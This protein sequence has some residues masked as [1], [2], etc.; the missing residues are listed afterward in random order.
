MKL[1][2]P[3][4]FPLVLILT[5]PV[6]CF[7]QKTNATPIKEADTEQYFLNLSKKLNDSLRF[8]PLL[9]EKVV[10][11]YKKSFQKSFDLLLSFLETHPSE[12]LTGSIYDNILLFHNA[13]IDRD[14]TLRQKIQFTDDR[15]RQLFGTRDSLLIALGR[16]YEL[17][18]PMRRN[19]LELEKKADDVET[20]ILNRLK[21]GK[22]H[23]M[24]LSV[25]LAHQVYQNDPAMAN[26]QCYTRI[27][28]QKGDKELADQIFNY[29]TKKDVSVLKWQQVCDELK[30]DE[31]AIEFV[32]YRY[33]TREKTTDT[34]RYGAL[35]L[36]KGFNT[37]Q[38]IPLCTQAQLDV[39]LQENINQEYH[40]FNL[41]TPRLSE[42]ASSLYSLIWQPLEPFIKGT[43]KIYYA[44]SGD[45]HRLNISAICPSDEAK[46]LSQQIEFILINSARS[47][48]NQYAKS[49]ENRALPTIKMPCLK[50]TV[51]DMEL[52]AD[53]LG[54]T[55]YDAPAP[56]KTRDAVL[57]GNVYYDMDSLAI[58]KGINKAFKINKPNEDKK[59]SKKRQFNE[60]TDWEVLFGTKTEIDSIHKIF[61]K[62]EYKVTIREGFAASEESFKEL[63]RGKPSPRILHIATH[64]FFFA[65]SLLQKTEN[66]LNRSGL[67][68]TGANYA[69]KK[70]RPMTG[71]EDGILTAF[72]IGQMNLQNT[73]LVVLSA[74]ETGLG[75]IENN[76]GVF[77]LQRAFKRAGVRNLM[78]SLWSIPDKATQVLMT[79]FYKNCLEKNMTLRVA[80]NEAQQW[81]RGQ[82]VYKNPYYWAGFILLE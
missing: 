63:G 18:I 19:A 2:S 44:P 65:D 35:L 80:L 36:K 75:Y 46:P 61:A 60:K 9:S 47:L 27:R 22:E 66:P 4:L 5:I 73:E 52:A 49:A 67:I 10:I 62:A 7:A 72:E 64:G 74:C 34:I 21:K 54:N 16:Q 13:S 81:M 48:M 45:L 1:V 37:P 33:Q 12:R 15:T 69:W 17:P 51:V 42:D 57:F 20:E 43:K 68:L 55:A 76:E 79:R 30:A 14:V 78:V 24:A 59:G 8:S 28:L 38:Y 6:F 53:L 40:L 58:K 70:G 3:I 82:E 32:S 31:T 41:Y 71:M 23:F 29:A 11:E 26:L 39:L 50:S 77:G 25:E 56:S